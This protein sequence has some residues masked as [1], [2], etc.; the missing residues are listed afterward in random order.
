MYKVIAIIK[1]TL[2]GGRLAIWIR[3]VSLWAC[4]KPMFA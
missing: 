4:W 2:L 1:G 3:V